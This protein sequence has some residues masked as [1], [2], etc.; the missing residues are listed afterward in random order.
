MRSRWLSKPT[1][2]GLFWTLVPRA[3]KAR[4]NSARSGHI[5]S[6]SQ[7]MNNISSSTQR[8]GGRHYY[9]LIRRPPPIWS[10]LT[11]IVLYALPDPIEPHEPYL[12]IRYVS[13]DEQRIDGDSLCLT[14]QEAKTYAE[15]EFGVGEADWQELPREQ[16][17]RIPIFD[18]G[19]RV[20]PDDL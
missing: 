1:P 13:F 9:A 4:Q 5:K 10:Y 11:S 19:I 18:R 14:L 16:L 20:Q 2:S 3:S 12:A 6:P 8:R 15:E 7:S 17:L